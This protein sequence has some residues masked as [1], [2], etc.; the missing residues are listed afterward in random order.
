MNKSRKLRDLEQREAYLLDKA[1][2]AVGRYRQARK[3]REFQES[4]ETIND[5][6]AKGLDEWP[7]SGSPMTTGS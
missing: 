3:M 4:F 2:A 7:Q 1:T 6:L 5:V